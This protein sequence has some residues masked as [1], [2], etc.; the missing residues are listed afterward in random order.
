M[1]LNREKHDNEKS[2]CRKDSRFVEAWAWL[3]KITTTYDLI[4][5]P[6]NTQ[7]LMKKG[8]VP[9]EILENIISFKRKFR[10][11]GDSN[12]DLCDDDADNN[13]CLISL[14]F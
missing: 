11:K 2:S 5:I 7:D 1:N 10:P 8:R 6:C 9:F 4:V 12:P 14:A 13:V 3:E